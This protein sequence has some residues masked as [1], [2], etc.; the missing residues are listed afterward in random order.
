MPITLTV[1]TATVSSRT[2]MATSQPNQARLGTRRCCSA[3]V[4][5]RS[6]RRAEVLAGQPLLLTAIDD[7]LQASPHSA[8]DYGLDLLIDGL[9]ARHDPRA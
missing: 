6:R 2:P 9:R 4:R 1:T 8:F 5:S 7:L 3:A